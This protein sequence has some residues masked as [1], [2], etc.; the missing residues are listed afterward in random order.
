MQDLNIA[1][2]EGDGVGP[3]VVAPT[4]ALLQGM[5]DASSTYRLRFEFLPGGAGHFGRLGEA[6]PEASIAAARGADAILMGPMGLPGVVH[7]SGTSVSPDRDLRAELG[8][9]A[10]VYPIRS[11]KGRVSRHTPYGEP[12]DCVVITNT[13]TGITVEPGRG[14]NNSDTASDK[15]VLTK[16]SSARLCAF[17]FA[18]ARRRKA[19]GIS[20]GRVTCVDKARTLQ[21][22]ALFRSVFDDEAATHSDI[23]A[24]HAHLNAAALEMMSPPPRYD[25]MVTD[26]LFGDVLADI[27]AGVMGGHGFAASAHIAEDSG[28]FQPCHG[29]APTMAERGWSNPLAMISSG[30]LMLDWLGTR[31]GIGALCLDAMRLEQAIDAVLVSGALRTRDMGGLAATLDMAMGVGDALVRR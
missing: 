16:D 24:D 14:P 25:V 31:T 10:S 23:L 13:L 21:T 4:L 12:V 2:F 20:E 7:P 1:V 5:S 22:F 27:G 9:F 15:L 18:A 30:A 3:E 6:L 19:R 11:P 26:S 29:S 8:L 17:A 28:L